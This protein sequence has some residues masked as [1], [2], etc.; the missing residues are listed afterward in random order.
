MSKHQLS[1]D[2]F[3]EADQQ[4]LASFSCGDTVVGRACTEWIRGSD[5]LDSMQRGSGVWLY[6]NSDDEIVGFGSLGPIR[7]RWPLPD[8][9]YAKL[10]II[11][12]LGIDERFQ[13]QPPGKEWRYSRQIMNHLIYEAHVFSA[14]QKKPVEWLLLLVHPENKPAIKLYEELDFVM[15]PDVRRGAANSCV[16]KHRLA[17]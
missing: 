1:A 14:M 16:M 9:D 12:M 6:R 5:V 10:A 2:L 4:Q 7:W 3:T 11:P 17:E 8:V 13:G 15:I